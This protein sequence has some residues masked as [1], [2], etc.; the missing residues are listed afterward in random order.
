MADS[1][2][3]DAHAGPGFK[4]YITVFVAL[5]VF[6]AISFLVNAT[7]GRNTTG[8]L[9]ILAVAVCKATLVG[10]YFMHLVIDWSKLYY[11]IIPALI[12]G[13]LLVVVLM[14]DIVLAWHHI[15]GVRTP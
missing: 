2:H 11:L 6:T 14:P 3:S 9:I 12:L 1:H 8:M 4:A 7:V 15:M 10:M 5:A 13:T